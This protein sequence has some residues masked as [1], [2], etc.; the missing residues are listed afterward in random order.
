MTTTRDVR[1]LLTL[2]FLESVG[3]QGSSEALERCE[4]QWRNKLQS[5]A[6][7][8]LNIREDGPQQLRRKKLLII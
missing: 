2:T 5:W 4:E 8:G 1:T 7:S 6:P 3:E